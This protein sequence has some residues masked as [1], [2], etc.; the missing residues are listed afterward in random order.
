V[1]SL[2]SRFSRSDDV[3]G[4]S[5]AKAAVAA[6]LEDGAV[7]TLAALEA[8]C[9][10]GGPESERALEILTRPEPELV[11]EAIRCVGLHS[12][13]AGVESLVPLVSHADW[14]VRAEAIQTLAD[15][16]LVSGIPAILRRLDTEQ[17]D[18]VRGV[19]LRAL[20][21]LESGVG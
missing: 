17:D 15:R 18:F 2:I 21:H 20:K 10:V 11:R 14:T 3:D 16:G 8:L 13:D 1:R 5:E 19:T 4:R 7:V 12:D 6:A 9:E